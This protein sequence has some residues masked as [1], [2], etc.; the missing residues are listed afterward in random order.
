MAAIILEIEKDE[1]KETAERRIMDKFK[2]VADNILQ[3]LEFTHD[4]PS[5]HREGWMPVLDLQVRTRGNKLEYKYY[6][7][8]CTNTYLI[9][10]RSAMA[11]TTKR[12]VLV[13]EGFRR[14]LNTMPGLEDEIWMDIMEEFAAKMLRSGYSSKMRKEVVH[15]ALAAYQCRVRQDSEGIRPLHRPKEYRKED[16]EREKLVKKETWFQGTAKPGLPEPEA[17]LFVEATP[18]IELARSIQNQLNN[19]KIPV[20]VAE[21][22]GPKLSQI[23]IKTDPYQ[24]DLCDRKEGCLVCS[25]REDS[26]MGKANCWQEGVTYSLKCQECPCVYIGETSST[27]HVRG[28]EHANQ[29]R[30]NQ[31]G[32]KGGE[33]SVMARHI[34]ER[35][36]GDFDTKFKMSVTSHHLNQTHQRQVS[37]AVRI[38]EVEED[39]L[40]NTRSERPSDLVSEAGARVSRGRHS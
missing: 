39:H 14:L 40:I 32:K 25:T 20:K 37:E 28:A 21:K 3:M 18:N 34:R 1:N 19:R 26:N 24:Q 17:V 10:E 13:Q 15:G 22:S 7:K 12:T 6:E 2:E 35:H 33:T 23:L 38:G 16:R 36:D 5:E 27:A 9:G 31:E 11:M 30:L 29:L 8:P 4:H